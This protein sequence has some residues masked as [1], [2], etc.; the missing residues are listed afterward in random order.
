MSPVLNQGRSAGQYLRAKV[1]ARDEGQTLGSSNLEHRVLPTKS[2]RL[3][4][5]LG[6]LKPLLLRSVLSILAVGRRKRQR[7]EGRQSPQGNPEVLPYSQEDGR[8]VF[9]RQA[10]H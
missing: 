4:V 2:V 9:A 1:Q 3:G 7:T 5:V 10:P 6:L 8:M